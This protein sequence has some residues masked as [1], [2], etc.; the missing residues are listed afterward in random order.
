MVLDGVVSL[1]TGDTGVFEVTHAA[2]GASPLVVPL[3]AEFRAGRPHRACPLFPPCSSAGGGSPGRK[4]RQDV[5]VVCHLVVPLEAD[6][7][8]GRP[9]RVCL[10]F[11]PTCF[12]GGGSPGQK[13]SQG[14]PVVCHL[15]IPLEAE[16]LA[17]TPHRA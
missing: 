15:I 6:L 2:E 7:P 11:P 13:T 9:H 4:T 10:L 5:P 3:E 17:G 8:A 14:V 1:A 12:T 16:F